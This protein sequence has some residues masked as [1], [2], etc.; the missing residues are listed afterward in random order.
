MSLVVYAFLFPS[1]AVDEAP[2]AVFQ[3]DYMEV[4]K[5]SERFAT[6]LQ[7]RKE[8]GLMDRAKSVHGFDFDYDKIGDNEVHAIAKV[9]LLASIHY[10]KAHLCLR[11]ESCIVQFELEACAIRALEE[12]RPKLRVHSHCRGDDCVAYFVGCK[13]MKRSCGHSGILLHAQTAAKFIRHSAS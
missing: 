5:Q 1:S 3:V 9:K 8:L 2:D 13:P 10:W 12:S 4:Y 11:T 7:V 6:Q